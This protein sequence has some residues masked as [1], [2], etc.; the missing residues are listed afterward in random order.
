MDYY[1]VLLDKGVQIHREEIV[2][3]YKELGL[4]KFS[5]S[6]MWILK[7]V[8]GMQEGLLLTEPIE[9]EGRKL[10]K[11]VLVS[12]NFGH[13][14]DNNIKKN[15][16]FVSRQLRRFSRKVRLVKYNSLGLVFAPFN[17]LRIE[18]W[19]RKI[20]SSYNLK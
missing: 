2:T 6:V 11:E 8:F 17:K 7:E 18:Y 19:R 4:I 1:F 3:R 14:D 5:E 10:L 13:F 16:T 20:I 15:E 12:G 9:S